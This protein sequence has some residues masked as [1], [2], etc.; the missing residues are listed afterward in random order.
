[1]KRLGIWC[2]AVVCLS[3]V[4]VFNWF[5]WRVLVQHWA[6]QQSVGQVESSETWYNT[7]IAENY[8]WQQSVRTP[9][10]TECDIVTEDSAIE[11]E[12]ARAHKSYE[13]LGQALH[14]ADQLAKRP[15][16]LFLLRGDDRDERQKIMERIGPVC[17]RLGVTVQWYDCKSGELD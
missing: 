13:A 8:G 7:V 11:I 10:G 16:I 6:G 17:V 12:W 4:M 2:S 15:G 3:T 14:Y 5:A 9:V 1:M